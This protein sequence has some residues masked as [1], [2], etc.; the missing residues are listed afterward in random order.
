M[1]LA[2]VIAGAFIL[3]PVDLT[4]L[5]VSALFSLMGVSNIY[6]WMKY[7]NYFAADAT[8]APL[9]HTWSLGIEEQFY[10][11]WPLFIV[12]LVRL[13]PRQVLPILGVGVLV[14]VGV[15]VVAGAAGLQA[16]SIVPA[17][18]PIRP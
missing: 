8:E 16:G 2:S 10:L 6:I 5:N 3:S 11:I 4:R 17:V 14:A 13:A 1:L 9:L 12:A 18:S 15:G 7:G